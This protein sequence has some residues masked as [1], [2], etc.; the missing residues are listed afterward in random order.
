MAFTRDISTA[1]TL[2]C[3]DICPRCT[4]FIAS[5]RAAAY[6]INIGREVCEIHSVALPSARDG[7][8]KLSGHADGSRVTA[9]DKNEAIKTEMDHD[10]T[11]NETTKRR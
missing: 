10:P 5:E 4:I 9:G 3:S 1:H 7:R 11:A 2:L 8:A 6:D